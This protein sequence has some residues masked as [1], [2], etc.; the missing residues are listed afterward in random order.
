MHNVLKIGFGLIVLLGPITLK[1]QNDYVIIKHVIIEG[2]KRTK[3]DIIQRDLFK[4][5]G[6]TIW[7]E[8]L[9]T[10]FAQCTSQLLNT[11]LFSDVRIN[12]KH[13]DQESKTADLF[14]QVRELWY[15]IPVPIFELADRNFSVWW[16]E[17]N[18]SLARVDYGLRMYHN[19]LSG[20]N[21]RL[22]LVSQFGYTQKLEAIY[23]QPFINKNKTL[24]IRLG[25]LYATQKEIAYTTYNNKN[26]FSRINDET[27][28]RRRILHI[29]LS[30]R[31]KFFYTHQ[32]QFKYHHHTI[33]PLVSELLNKY[34]FKPPDVV[35]RYISL[36]YQMIRDTRDRYIVPKKGSRLSVGLSARGLGWSAA[37]NQI[38]TTVFFEKY[39]T[40]TD[41][42]ALETALFLK[43]EWSD[44]QPPYF[45]NRALGF[46]Q[47][48]VRGYELYVI[49]GQDYGLLKSAFRYQFI[50]KKINWD[51]NMPIQQLRRMPLD[52]YVHVH[53]DAAYVNERYFSRSN[54]L[55]NQ[56]IYGYGIGFDIVLYNNY[57]FQFDISQNKMGEIGL[58]FQYKLDF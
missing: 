39:W 22:K 1:A 27:L 40:A 51:N 26:L 2:H 13:W 7:L 29:R 57:L 31:N 34:Y 35:Q 41:H 17:Q 9:A 54:L 47:F 46:G 53:L 25:F 28:L 33:N 32:F 19:N 44:H 3:P 42:W 38:R 5:S 45:Q 55:A 58:F 4:Q 56:Y 36:S 15:W 50:H 10:V 20:R 52:A 6:D 18:R 24:G 43:K 16:K 30:H 11:K 21:D 8:S 49:D 14:V 23:S 48:F 37:V 12:L